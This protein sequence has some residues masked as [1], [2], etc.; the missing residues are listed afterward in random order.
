MSNDDLW[1]NLHSD[2]LNQIVKYVHSYED[3]ARLR[4]VCKSWSLTLARTPEHKYPWL[5][6]LLSAEDSIETHGP[7]EE[8]INQM[9]LP[10]M[11]DH[12]FRGSCCGFL[13]IL[14]LSDG[15]LHL[16]NPFTKVI[17][18]LPP[19]S[20]LPHIVDYLPENI[21]NEYMM[22]DMV[23]GSTGTVERILV[24]KTSVYKIIISSPP[25][26]DTHDFMAVVI[27]GD[28]RR[29]GF[30]RTG[31]G[32]WTDIPTAKA[33]RCE[34]E[35][36]IFNEGKIHA[37]DWKAQ[38]YEFDMHTKPI[39]L[40]GATKAKPPIGIP[41]SRGPTDWNFKYLAGHGKGRLLMVVRHFVYPRDGDDDA[42]VYRTN[43]FSVYM[44]TNNEV[45][46]RVYNLENYALVLG[47]N[48]SISMPCASSCTKPNHIYYTDNLL[49]HYYVSE[50]GHKRRRRLQLK[51]CWWSLGVFDLEGG[52][53]NQLFSAAQF[54]LPPPVWLC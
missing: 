19:I 52:G 37:V 45:W 33:H 26:R 2:L 48:S 53:N 11:Q 41:Q 34:F 25:D 8:E 29:L 4:L 5:V 50:E 42:D 32:G 31:D 46:S 10:Q 36:V 47:L 54:L 17:Y 35:D 23:N 51:W 14:G 13:V 39:P 43:T 40:G 3:Y 30:H 49:E 15:A 27:Y 6:S 12:L 22:R 24:N 16:L 20:T 1:A 21:G 38:L 7:I 44:L 9:R 18:D 28:Y